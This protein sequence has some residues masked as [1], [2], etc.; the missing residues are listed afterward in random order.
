[1]SWDLLVRQA[2]WLHARTSRGST[3]QS[4]SLLGVSGCAVC[5][6]KIIPAFRHS[7]RRMWGGDMTKYKQG[8]ERTGVGYWMAPTGTRT[9]LGFRV[10]W[11]IR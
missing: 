8:E 4:V 10:L 9:D 1:M 6:M 7:S 3:W 5:A 2:V 11:R